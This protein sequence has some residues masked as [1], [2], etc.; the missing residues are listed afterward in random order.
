MRV[1]AR[2]RRAR[3]DVQ[4]VGRVQ[5]GVRGAGVRVGGRLLRHG[6]PTTIGR[7]L[8]AFILAVFI[9]A[10][11]LG[12]PP[13]PRPVPTSAYRARDRQAGDVARSARRDPEIVKLLGSALQSSAF[14]PPTIWP[15]PFAYY[16]FGDYVLDG[17]QVATI[18]STVAA[19]LVL[20]ALF[21]YTTIGL[22]MRAVVESPRMT[23]LA[24]INADRVSSVLVDAVEPVRRPRGRAARAAVRAAGGA[25]LHDPV[26]RRDRGRRLRSPDEH[27][28][29][30]PR[31][32]PAR[33]RA[34]ASS[35]ATCRATASSPTDCGRRCRSSCCS[36]CCCSGPGC[37]SAVRSPTRSPASTHRRRGWRP[38]S[39][40]ARSPTPRG[41]SVQWSSRSVCTSR[42]SS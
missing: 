20:T 37:A 14:N 29:R 11:L 31:R 10:P 42:C 4:D 23:E 6:Q 34:R 19:V 40:C 33:H 30:A 5:P 24:G 8:P 25:Q 27:P 41:C 15:N 26:G 38:P 21:R 39:G 22:Q 28:A 16:H 7:S 35:P 32:D 18:I 1:R 9:V 12:P 17:N 13:R 36:S 3:P 2:R